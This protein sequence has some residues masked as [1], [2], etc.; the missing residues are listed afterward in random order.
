MQRA[1]QDASFISAYD[2]SRVS[3]LGVR[4]PE[5]LAEAAARELALKQGLGVVVSGSIEPQRNR[6]QDLGQGDSDGNGRCD[7]QP[8]HEVPADKG[9]GSR[10]S[11]TSDGAG[12]QRARRPDIGS[13][14]GLCDEKRVSELA[15]SD[16]SLRGGDE[17]PRPR[18]TG[19]VRGKASRKPWILI[20]RLRLDTGVWQ[21]WRATRVGSAEIPTRTSR[22]R[23]CSVPNLT[24]R[25]RLTTRGFDH[26]ATGDNSQ[27]V[28]EHNQLLSRYQADVVARK[29]AGDLSEEPAKH[30][31]RNR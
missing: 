5:K 19:T 21:P 9:P 30:A 23:S 7:H 15:G 12:S 11:D 25:E 13:R 8:V 24:E 29:H 16:C 27:C 26:W 18:G 14:S 10:N 1:L 31:R 3:A 2:R 28:K 22:R 20:P 6:V 4:P 17:S